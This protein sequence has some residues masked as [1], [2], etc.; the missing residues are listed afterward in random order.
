MDILTGSN[1]LV[2]AAHCD[3]V[4]ISCVGWLAQTRPLARHAL[5]LVGEFDSDR[6]FISEANLDMC[7]VVSHYGRES[8]CTMTVNRGA[9]ALLDSIIRDNAIDTIVT[10]TRHDSHQDHRTTADIVAAAIRRK[11]IGLI[12]MDSCSA[13]PDFAPNLCIALTPEAW[14]VKQSLCSRYASLAGPYVQ[15]DWLLRWHTDRH[16]QIR[17]IEC[18]ERYR[19]VQ[20]WHGGFNGLAV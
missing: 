20:L 13:T 16:A 19:V 10:H 7:G 8:D 18:C 17:G 1:V 2:V 5:M 9:V 3:D 15:P 6:R 14:R 4:E 12:E 11:R